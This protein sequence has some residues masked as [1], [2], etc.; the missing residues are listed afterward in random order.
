MTRN[1][2]RNFRQYDYISRYE[3][4]P[5]FYDDYNNRY[6]YGITANLNSDTPYAAYTVKT[7]DTYDSIA[8]DVYSHIV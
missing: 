4:F 6:Y 7:G 5:Y 2:T 8:Y 1:R 3:S